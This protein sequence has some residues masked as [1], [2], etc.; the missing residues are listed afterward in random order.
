MFLKL[1]PG[2]RLTSQ[3]LLCVIDFLDNCCLRKELPIL[4]L[5]LTYNDASVS[6]HGFS[7]HPKNTVKVSSC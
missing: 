4:G 6:W 2:N 1:S 7:E 3:S 5:D